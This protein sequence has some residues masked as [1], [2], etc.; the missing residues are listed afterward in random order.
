[1]APLQTPNS[2]I[3]TA[4]DYILEKLSIFARNCETI[5]KQFDIL[6]FLRHH[7]A[8]NDCLYLSSC[9]QNYL[10]KLLQKPSTKSNITLDS[11]TSWNRFFLRQER[12]FSQNQHEVHHCCALCRFGS[13]CCH[14]KKTYFRGKY[15]NFNTQCFGTKLACKKV[16]VFTKPRK[17]GSSFCCIWFVFLPLFCCS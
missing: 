10:V 1:M 15:L 2:K 5:V 12:L 16:A 6:L 11:T 9:V 8:G 17:S 14:G 4:L 13:G 3:R 7:H